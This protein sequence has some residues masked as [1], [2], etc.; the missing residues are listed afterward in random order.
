MNFARIIVSGRL[1]KDATYVPE[2]R[3]TAGNVTQRKRLSFTVL[4]NAYRGKDNEDETRAFFCTA[5][6]PMADS[7]KEILKVGKEVLIEGDPRPYPIIGLK[8]A[9]GKDKLVS[10][11]GITIRSIQLGQ[12][13]KAQRAARGIAP[14][15]SDAIHEAVKKALAEMT[16]QST[17]APANVQAQPV[18]ENPFD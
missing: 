6:G 12:D 4:M 7:Y 5:W 11:F 3:D 14:V 16:G 18:D 8:T 2:L 13:G 9:D 1:A 15:S 17:P 10:G